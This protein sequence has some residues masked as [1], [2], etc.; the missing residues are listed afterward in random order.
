MKKLLTK[1]RMKFMQACPHTYIRFSRWVSQYMFPATTK[2]LS[3][4]SRSP[5]RRASVIF[6]GHNRCATRFISRCLVALAKSEGRPCIDLETY[7]A[8]TDSS[9]YGQFEDP[10]FMRRV[11]Q[12]TGYYYGPHYWYREIPGL[13]RFRVLLV[14]RDPRDV[15]T[16]RYYSQGFAH[17][18]MDEK[19]YR[20]RLEIQKMTVDEFVREMAWEVKC[21]YEGYLENL[22]PRSNVYATSYEK[23]V[24][25]FRPWL[26]GI[27]EHIGMQPSAAAVEQVVASTSFKVAKEDI[28][29]HKRSVQPGSHLRKLTPETV[30]FL[31]REYA[32]ILEALDYPQ[33]AST[34]G[35]G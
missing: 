21:A 30:D 6:F 10:D 22:L 3:G 15:I 28:Y 4:R 14:L 9:R 29:S 16:S 7:F 12:P 31:N 23:M 2:L 20:R 26:D 35:A 1:L 18:L 11:F 33:T 19:A 34:A 5:I 24:A 32:T 8:R 27:V 13:E 25:D 17:T